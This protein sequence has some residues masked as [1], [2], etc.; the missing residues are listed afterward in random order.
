MPLLS[1]KLRQCN[2]HVHALRQL[3]G[4]LADR[5]EVTRQVVRGLINCGKLR[6]DIQGLSGCETRRLAC[7]QAAEAAAPAA[8]AVPATAATAAPAVPAAAAAAAAAAAT[9]N[10]AGR[11][12][13]YSLEDLKDL[14]SRVQLLMGGGSS[15]GGP[16]QGLSRQQFQNFVR[17]VDLV[18]RV[19][20]LAGRLV[21]S[22]HLAYRKLL[23]EVQPGACQL[24]GRCATSIDVGGLEAAAP[25]FLCCSRVPVLLMVIRSLPTNTGPSPYY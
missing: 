8:P 14:R 4:S 7:R 5:S 17:G 12:R 21:R 15:G 24:G 23:M 16:M 13:W 2:E 11:V 9:Q 20:D 1:F 22:G 19:V 18:D 10:L 25:L 6:F 3:Y